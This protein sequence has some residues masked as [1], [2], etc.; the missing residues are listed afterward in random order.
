MTS[1]YLSEPR[2]ITDLQIELMNQ[3][4]DSFRA[5]IRQHTPITVSELIKGIDC[6]L[7]EYESDSDNHYPLLDLIDY[8]RT[9]ES[10]PLRVLF[11][12]IVWRAF[13]THGTGST[14][15]LSLAKVIGKSTF[16]TY[17]YCTQ[18]ECA[19][20][21]ERT[22]TI[23]QDY[24]FQI[25]NYEEYNQCWVEYK[26]MPEESVRIALDRMLFQMWRKKYTAKVRRL[27]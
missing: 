7:D 6:L 13:C 1:M 26:P 3:L 27:S 19:G 12:Y 18:L 11:L 4:G 24:M 17:A 25:V 14:P 23:G 16:E 2:L 8:Q 10:E 5:R 21:I 22:N 20:R 15:L 9:K